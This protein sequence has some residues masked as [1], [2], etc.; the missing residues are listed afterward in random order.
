MS[1]GNDPGS[2]ADRELHEQSAEETNPNDS[3]GL[4]WCD[5][6]ASKHIHS[7]GQGLAQKL[8]CSEFTREH[9]DV[10]F[11]NHFVLRESMLADVSHPVSDL[12]SIHFG[13]Q[14]FHLAHRLVTGC[15]GRERI[16]KPR[17]ALP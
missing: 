14:E 9:H 11:G 10:T 17:A 6:S 3:N 8:G 15:A 7:A 1:H 13:S 12:H 2:F 4:P 16:L 5:L